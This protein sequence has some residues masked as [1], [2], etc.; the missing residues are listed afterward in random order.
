MGWLA[1]Q[2]YWNS[3][4]DADPRK[5]F[6]SEVFATVQPHLPGF[7]RNG[8]AADSNGHRSWTFWKKAESEKGIA[9]DQKNDGLRQK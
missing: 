8:S 2:S 9:D 3:I 6:A 5:A 1:A 4:E 7:S